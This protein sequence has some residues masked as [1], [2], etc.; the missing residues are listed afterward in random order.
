MSP[1]AELLK[2]IYGIGLQAIEPSHRHKSQ[3]RGKYL[4]HQSLVLRMDS[5]PLVKLA[6]MF[7]RV[8]SII[9][10]GEHGLMESLRK[11]HPLYLACERWFGDLIQRLAHGIIS[12]AFM[13]QTLVSTFMMVFVIV[14]ESLTWWSSWPSP[15]I[16]I[17]FIVRGHIKTRRSSFPLCTAQL[18]F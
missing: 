1:R 14:G 18:L 10:S 13:R 9:V 4:L 3:T 2:R 16:I 17:L 15:I 12:Q 5:H 6:Y 8:R 7:Y 11:F